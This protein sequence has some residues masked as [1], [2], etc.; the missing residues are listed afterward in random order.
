M[1]DRTLAYAQ[2]RKLLAGLDQMRFCT[3]DKASG[4]VTKG[5]TFRRLELVR[6]DDGG[7]P[8]FLMAEV[9]I[10]SLPD[11][12]TVEKLGRPGTLHQL[13]AFVERPVY[14]LN[15]TGFTF[16]V[17]WRPLAL[18]RRGGAQLPSFARLPSAP[19]DVMYA[20]P[21]GQR[22]NGPV[23]KSLSTLGHALIGGH[24]QSGKSSWIQCGLCA[25][26][27]RHSPQALQLALVDFK[28]VELAFWREMAHL[29]APVAI[30]PDQAEIVTRLVLE[31]VD[32]RQHLFVEAKTRTWR[33]YNATAKKPLPV[34][35][36]VIDEIA[37]LVLTEGEHHPV[38][39]NLAR[40]TQRGAALGVFTWVATQYPR[41]DVVGALARAQMTTRIAFRMNAARESV[42]ILD[43]SGAEKIPFGVPGRNLCRLPDEPG[44]MLTQGFYL[45]DKAIQGVTDQVA[46]DKPITWADVAPPEDISDDWTEMWGY[47]WPDDLA[48]LRRIFTGAESGHQAAII[49]RLAREGHSQS[50]IERG[51]FGYTGGSAFNV[52]S[53]ALKEGVKC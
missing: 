35:L 9:D 33:I 24:T 15:G 46:A 31:E 16:V 11:A 20:V 14:C 34:I 8:L 37:D 50:E 44:L 36:L 13:G 5:V 21:V 23:W 26:V 18:A 12:V 41:S 39:K 10:T 52:V 42:V 51:L 38:M 17:D 30:T 40:I 1:N 32:R 6:P 53:K 28:A 4:V 48:T 3:K 45:D 2:A 25:L 47:P 27:E 43:E 7:R 49:R 29:M 22:G 19:S